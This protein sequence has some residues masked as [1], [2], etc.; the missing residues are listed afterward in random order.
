MGSFDY[1]CSISGLPIG[2]Q[3]PVRFMILAEKLGL[4]RAIP[5]EVD[6]TW[7]PLAP[8]IRARYNAYGSVE[9]DDAREVEALFDVLNRRAVERGVGESPRRDMA[10]TR[11]MPPEDWLSALWLG[12]VA[13]EAPRGKAEVAQ[14][15]I[16]EDI[17]RYL[18][19]NHGMIGDQ[20][21]E[22]RHID[23]S[24]RLETALDAQVIRDRTLEPALRELYAVTH[25]LKRL[26]RPWAPGTCCGPQDGLWDYHQ[27]FAEKVA[28]I[29]SEAILRYQK[30]A[31]FEDTS[32]DRDRWKRSL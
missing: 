20:P 11:G 31:A 5:F 32:D 23:S 10:V 27:R 26:G 12:R 22:W 8:P 15:M 25:A 21:P 13:I 29:A 4:R 3:T 24:M 9:F 30:E 7:Q 14:A 19:E 6:G 17:W 1:S 16:R 2:W 28:S 18:L